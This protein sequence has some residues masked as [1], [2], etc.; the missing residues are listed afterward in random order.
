MAILMLLISLAF[1]FSLYSEVNLSPFHNCRRAINPRSLRCTKRSLSNFV[2]ETFVTKF[3]SLEVRQICEELGLQK[4]AV[5]LLGSRAVSFRVWVGTVCPLDHSIPH[6]RGG[7]STAHPADWGILDTTVS[8]TFFLCRLPHRAEAVRCQ[9]LS[10]DRLLQGLQLKTFWFP[11]HT[12]LRNRET[13]ELCLSGVP[14]W[15][16]FGWHVRMEGKRW[17]LISLLTADGTGQFLPGELYP[18]DALFRKLWL[19]LGGKRLTSWR[20]ARNFR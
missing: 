13:G 20:R 14:I 2:T 12:V 19:T 15:I 8:K 18:E 9:Q 16:L 10:P 11:S 6:I 1:N 17:L 3:F 5:L 7:T 4:G